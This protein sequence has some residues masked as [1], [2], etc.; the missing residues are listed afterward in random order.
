MPPLLIKTSILSLKNLAAFATVSRMSLIERRLQRP[1]E[2]L[3]EN[4]FRWTLTQW[5]SSSSSKSIM[6]T[7]W[8][9]WRNVRAR[10]RPI[11]RAAPRFDR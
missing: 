5:L 9:R 4:C 8:P 3:F 7:L 10:Q 6:N 1:E 11:P 2:T